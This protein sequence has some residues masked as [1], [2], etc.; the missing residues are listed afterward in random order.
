MRVVRREGEGS[1]V[2]V[3]VRRWCGGGGGVQCEVVVSSVR[4]ER[5]RVRGSS[6]A[7]DIYTEALCLIRFIWQ[8][9][10]QQ[11]STLYSRRRGR[12]EIVRA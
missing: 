6:G 3:V 2:V 4:G 5:V 9:A 12:R 11:R 8:P 1:E 10:W 7:V